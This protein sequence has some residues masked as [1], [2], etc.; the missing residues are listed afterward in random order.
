VSLNLAFIGDRAQDAPPGPDI[1]TFEPKQMFMPDGQQ[2]VG[3]GPFNNRCGELSEVAPNGAP[4]TDTENDTTRLFQV[5]SAARH[6]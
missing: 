1:V 6:A 2:Y 5:S 4:I 3:G